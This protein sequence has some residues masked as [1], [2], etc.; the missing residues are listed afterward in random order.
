[1][2]HSNLQRPPKS[3][4]ITQAHFYDI[5]LEIGGF[6]YCEAGVMGKQVFLTFGLIPIIEMMRLMRWIEQFI[7]I[8]I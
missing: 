1:M 2:T 6:V 7:I 5:T 8:P 3:T 4:P